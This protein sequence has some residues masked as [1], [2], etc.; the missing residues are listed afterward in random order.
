MSSSNL[1]EHT[2][3]RQLK[4]ELEICRIG[5][6]FTGLYDDK[7]IVDVIIKQLKRDLPNI[8]I[9]K[10]EMNS[11]KVGFPTFFEQSFKQTGK[12][13]NIFNV[14]YIEQLS[15]E[16]Q[17]DFISYLQ[18]TRERFKSLP[19]SI[20]FWITKE[21]EK[22]LFLS[23]PDFFHWLSGSYD[24]TNVEL[25]NDIHVSTSDNKI[26]PYNHKIQDYL[27]KVT[28]EYENWKKTKQNKAAFLIEVMSR[29]DLRE[30]YVTSF[31]EDENCRKRILD[32]IFEEF[33]KDDKKSFLT[34]LGDFGTGK[35]SFAL[36]YYVKLAKQYLLNSLLNRI[37]IFISLK[38]YE[39]RLNIEE[40][41]LKEFFEKFDFKLTYDLF[42][43]LALRGKF[44]FF[45]DGF[46][47]MA[48]LSD[49]Q[50]TYDNLEELTKLSFENILFMTKNA[51]KQYKPNKVF[52]TCRTHYFLSDL[53]VKEILKAD[54]TVMYRNYAKKE[55]YEITRISLKEFDDQQIEEY[56]NKNTKDIIVT[57]KILNIIRDTYNLRELS[58]RPLL[59]EMIVKTLPIIQN[60]REMN[61]STLYKAYTSIWIGREDWRSQMTSQGKRYLMWNL[62][63]KMFVK[64][65]DFSL[66]YSELKKPKKEHFKNNVELVD[67]DYFRYETT[68]CSFL[69]RD[70][71]GNYKFIHKSFMEYFLAEYIFDTIKNSKNRGTRFG[72][73]PRLNK[74]TVFFLNLIISYNRHN[75]VNL[76]LR[77]LN[78][79]NVNLEFANLSESNLFGVNLKGANLKS[80]NLDFANLSNANLSK[81]NL[82]NAKLDKAHI[83]ETIFD[84]EH[85]GG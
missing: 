69:N 72:L 76:D 5:G 36:Y 52:L 53:Q 15:N 75:L 8:F 45:I 64:G 74:E 13:S 82:S 61:A 9:F 22:Q 55:N 65:G 58:A 25:H 3:Y 30:Y 59:L 41:I 28:F 10:L 56:I 12:K 7:R 78:L 6:L 54:Y 63:I 79:E 77:K 81:A 16:L 24:F 21:F 4:I 67:E 23:A 62:S 57:R 1:S 70:E 44:I 19:Y 73:F 37:P 39:G 34:L 20:V 35:T 27:K 60:Q 48:S 38:D 14:V 71:S 68:T 84:K 49:E 47:E 42:Q 85:R 29:A 32:D 83:Y 26:L 51:E 11:L 43:E 66:H 31:C 17:R 40:L 18:F 50:V 46:D 80:A 33:L 2:S